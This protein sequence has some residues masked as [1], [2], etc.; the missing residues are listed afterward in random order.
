[1]KLL[2][3]IT[4]IQYQSLLQCCSDREGAIISLLWYS[5]MR[6]SEA[7]NIKAKDFD[8]SEGTVIVLGKGNR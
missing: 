1:M 3:A 8:W 2:P 6:V 4:E 7:A 5:G